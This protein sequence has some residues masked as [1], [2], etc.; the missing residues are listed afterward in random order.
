LRIFTCAGR[1]V[2]VYHRPRLRLAATWFWT[3]EITTAITVV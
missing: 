2:R 3:G 1:I